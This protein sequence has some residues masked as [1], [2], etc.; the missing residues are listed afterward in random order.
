MEK[1]RGDTFRDDIA[2]RSR[3]INDKWQGLLEASRMDST[4]RSTLLTY[5]RPL[6]DRWMNFYFEEGSLSI[7]LQMGLIRFAEDPLREVTS[8]DAKPGSAISRVRQGWQSANRSYKRNSWTGANFVESQLVKV[9][10]D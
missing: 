5:M 2:G 8:L 4:V 3:E 7:S 1:D 9:E 10:L 6:H